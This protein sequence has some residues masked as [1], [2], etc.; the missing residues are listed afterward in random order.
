MSNPERLRTMEA[1]WEAMCH[2]FE[3]PQS[4][5]WHQEILASRNL[6]LVAGNANFVSIEEARKRLQG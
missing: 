2:E 5:S 4:P 3:E 1:L 6:R